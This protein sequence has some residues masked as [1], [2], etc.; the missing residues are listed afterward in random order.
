MEFF[1]IF[2][3][4]PHNAKIELK[5]TKLSNFN[6]NNQKIFLNWI[7]EFG[8]ISFWHFCLINIW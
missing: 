3:F 1:H 8:N 2:I 5:L 6:K 7:F 4:G